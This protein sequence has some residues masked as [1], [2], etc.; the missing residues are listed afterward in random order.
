MPLILPG[1]VAS[2]TAGAYSVANSCRFNHPDGPA[3]TKTNSGSS[4]T[5][6]DKYTISAWV[7]R[8]VLGGY[9]DGN[10]GNIIASDTSAYFQIYFKDDDT[11]R[12]QE[13]DGSDSLGNLITNRVFRDTSAWY[14]IVCR[15]DSSDGTSGDRMQIWINGVRE[16]SFAP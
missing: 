15:Y 11:L 1:N 16:T 13:H 3:L 9:G 7:K 4:A 2:A 5:D 12:W 14:H 6:I 10:G 8:C